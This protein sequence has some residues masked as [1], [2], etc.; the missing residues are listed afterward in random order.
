MSNPDRER[1][2][3]ASIR[4]AVWQAMQK[5]PDLDRKASFDQLAALELGKIE[6]LKYLFDMTF[7]RPDYLLGGITNLTDPEVPYDP[8]RRMTVFG[9][10]AFLQ[11]YIDE[12]TGYSDEVRRDGKPLTPEQEKDFW[13]TMG[14]QHLGNSDQETC[15][16]INW[17]QEHPQEVADFFHKVW[18]PGKEYTGEYLDF[19]QEGRLKQI[20]L[21]EDAP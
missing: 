16:L 2:E 14:F 6:T 5:G 12:V 15:Q 20:N 8:E 3:E 9:V 10:A 21:G 7:R 18:G 11:V 19:A 1:S 4:F 13:F 17:M